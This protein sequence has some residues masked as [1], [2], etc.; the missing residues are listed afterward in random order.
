M[1]PQIR[2]RILDRDGETCAIC[3]KPGACIHHIDYDDT[4]DADDNLITLCRPCHGKTNHHRIWWERL[5]KTMDESMFVEARRQPVKSNLLDD[6]LEVVAGKHEQAKA[7][8][9]SRKD[10]TTWTKATRGRGK[11]YKQAL[12]QA[13]L[14]LCGSPYYALTRQRW[15][16]EAQTFLLLF[17]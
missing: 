10:L 15:S 1:L 16:R 13:A 5:F 14:A 17:E 3:I 12:E 11:S 9:E 8:F 6:V 7:F 4:N 2:Q